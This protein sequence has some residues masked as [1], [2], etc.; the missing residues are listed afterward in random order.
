VGKAS[1]GLRL[2]RL[3]SSVNRSMNALGAAM[4]RRGFGYVLALTMMVV[5]VGAAGDRLSLR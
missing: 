1:R 3:I 5:F 2:L 4:R